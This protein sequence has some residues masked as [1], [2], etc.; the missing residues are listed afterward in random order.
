MTREITED[1]PRVDSSTLY[2]DGGLVPGAERE[3]SW[4]LSASVLKVRTRAAAEHVVVEFGRGW[5]GP[6]SQCHVPLERVHTRTYFLCPGCMGRVRLLYV[7][8]GRVACR[9]CHALRYPS[10]GVDEITRNLQGAQR[11]RALLGWADGAPLAKP[12]RMSWKRFLRL[13]A[14]HRHYEDNADRLITN[15]MR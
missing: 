7:V 4:V 12:K 14:Q 13:V 8:A 9:Q 3:R 2:R 10:E 11:I 15:C 1:Y 5:D 6:L